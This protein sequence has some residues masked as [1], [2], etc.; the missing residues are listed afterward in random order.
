MEN[1]LEQAVS[2]HKAGQLKKAGIC[3]KKVLDKQPDNIIALSNYGTILY[4]NGRLDEAVNC[5]IKATEVKP[6]YADAHF[7]LGAI[8]KEQEKWEGAIASLKRAIAIK[9]DVIQAYFYIATILT[10]QEN[11]PEA[12]GYYKKTIAL[13][14]DHV[15]ANNNLGILLHKQGNLP[16]AITSFKRALAIQP[17]H[18]AVHNNLGNTYKDQGSFDLAV[19]SFN[20]A[21]TLNPAIFELHVNLGNVLTILGRVDEAVKCFKKAITIKP[22]NPELFNNLG[23]ALKDQGKIEEAILNFKKA[24]SL[25][26]YYPAAHC[27]LIF[28]TDLLTDSTTT[29]LQQMRREWAKKYADPLMVLWT[30]F[31]NIPDQTRKLKIGYVGAD[32]RRHSAAM[33]FGPVIFNHNPD[34]FQI[35]CYAGN[36]DSD[37][38]TAKFK[39]Y[40]Y[41]WLQTSHLDDAQL[42]EQIKNDGI[43]ILIDLAGHT[44]GNRLLTFARKPAPIQIT[45]WGYPLGTSMKAM[46]YIFSDPLS[47]P[48]NDREQYI[49]TIIDLKCILHLDS[50][51]FVKFPPVNKLPATTTGTVTFGTFNRLEKNSNESYSTW[52]KILQNIPNSKLLLKAPQLDSLQ[53]V[54]KIKTTF[55]KIGI[56]ES[57]IITMGKSS[58]EEHLAA[59]HLIDIMLDPFPH[60]GGVTTLESLKMGVPVLTCI[61]KSI[62][63]D[64]G[65]ML[66][67]MGLDNWC[68]K[69]E[70][71]YVNLAKKFAADIDSLA[72]LRANLRERFEKSLVGNSPLY[73]AHIEEIYR[74]LW[75]EWCNKQ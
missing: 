69:D 31:N 15:D 58:Q 16:D 67:I 60:S 10:K 52:G 43:D 55:K 45:A 32:F 41:K 4:G 49:E 37:D 33:I 8:L 2:F 13:K 59:H 44:R 54:E 74:K 7:N 53:Q 12:I 62:F 26:K 51:N 34:R 50:D 63:C 19:A 56:A 6:D 27:N 57:R 35:Y 30:P 68:A 73:T 46:D 9:P 72:L 22:D 23:A 47:I 65:G 3:Y 70:V 40:A 18:L 29:K 5:F 20:K 21:I 24:I 48:Y 28:T 71:D 64:S 1:S 14:P 75:Q 61:E 11:L 17:N 36:L 42:A 25:Q 66:Q 39:R 38:L